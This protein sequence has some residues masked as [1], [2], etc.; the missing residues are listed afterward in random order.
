MVNWETG[1]PRADLHSNESAAGNDDGKSSN[2][3][4]P[5]S[6]QEE[7]RGYQENERWLRAKDQ[8]GSK[9]GG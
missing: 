7:C 6:A 2:S 8:R 5:E 3:S 1:N 9:G 4:V